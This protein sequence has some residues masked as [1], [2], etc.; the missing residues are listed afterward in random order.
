MLPLS[1]RCITVLIVATASLQVALPRTLL[2][3]TEPVPD[4]L[5]AFLDRNCIACHNSARPTANLALDAEALDPREAPQHA[6]IWEKVIRKLRTGAMP[7]PNR[8]PRPNARALVEFVSRL[9]TMIDEAALRQP[10]VGRPVAHRLN[11]SE[12]ANVIRDLLHLKID[13]LE[14]LPPDDAGY[15]FDNIGDVLTVSP[16]LLERYMSAAGKIARL[17]TG[18]AVD[19]SSHIYT[20]S[21]YLRQN[22]RMGEDLPFGSRG[23]MAVRH[24]FP[25]TGEYI[26]KLRL[27]KSL[28]DQIRGLDQVHDLE[29]RLDG[30][31]QQLFTIGRLPTEQP[32]RLDDQRRQ[33]LLHADRDLNVRVRTTAGPHV[34]LAAFLARPTVPEG[35]LRPTVS[36]A[37]YAFDDFA[38]MGR[39]EGPGLRT[40]TIDGPFNVAVNPDADDSPS[41]RRLFLCHPADATDEAETACTREIFSRL[42][43]RAYR[44]PITNADLDPLLAF[45]EEGRRQDGFERAVELT[46]RKILVSPEFLFR[47][48]H[49]PPNIQPGKAH[50]LSD[51]ELA[52]RLSF[53]LW[54]SIPDDELL[55]LAEH[56]KLSDPIVLQQQVER[57]LA[58][59]RSTALINN[60]AGQWL[61]LRNMQLVMPDP[62]A[63]PEFDDNLRYAFQRETELFLVSQLSEDRSVL[64]LLEADYSFLNERLARHYG[65]PKIYG[66]HFRRV[67]LPGTTRRGLLGH[68]SIL[69]VTSYANRTSPVLRGKWLLENLLGA[70]PPPPPA[71]VPALQKSGEG[72]APP[73]SVRERLEQHRRNPVCASCHAQMDPL[74][75]ALENFDAVGKWRTMGEGGMP[76]DASAI[77]PDGTTISGPAELVTRL[78]VNQPN[79][80][81][82][83]VVEKLLT[84]AIG[85]GIEYYDAPA[86]RTIV[87]D[88]AT[89]EYRWSS[90][91]SGIVKSA[92]FQ[93]R[94]SDGAPS[95][96]RRAQ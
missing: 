39:N 49:A 2:A 3:Q 30:K 42:A 38:A 50:R 43:R 87:R 7:P 52:S 15:G 71:N 81:A 84:Y 21:K 76:I 47:I 4:E 54:S 6:D 51:V 67:Q 1:A 94:M 63:F 31:R 82:S 56:G 44:R 27:Q 20:L 29:V 62:E 48:E 11:R 13:I 33:Y 28:R 36:V 69:T 34:V 90:L 92:P 35:P 86:I 75:F 14:L 70:P 61:Y 10:M 16:M 58:D 19:A 83:T 17:A 78:F 26:I 8:R 55:G 40:I 9:E 95:D 25:A 60:F 85:R 57:M 65:V 18:S 96:T 41:R 45:F 93:M 68:G 79:L 53:F 72:G 74:G 22:D 77:L 89:H 88:A 23:G 59:R 46:L 32:R 12:Y 73:S 37:S 91:I 80:F 64:E 66:S 24:T 5:R